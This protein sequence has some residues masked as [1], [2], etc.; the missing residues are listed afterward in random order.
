MTLVTMA[1]L[2]MLHPAFRGRSLGETVNSPAAEDLD[3]TIVVVEHSW[4]PMVLTRVPV[5][6][7]RQQSGILVNCRG[8]PPLPGGP[9]PRAAE[10]RPPG[11]RA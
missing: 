10:P 11:H 1:A 5:E 8:F 7:L 6:K 3:T 2:E 9:H 4:L